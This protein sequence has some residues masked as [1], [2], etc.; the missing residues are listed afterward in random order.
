MKRQGFTLIELLVVIAIIGILVSLLFPAFAAVRAAARSTQ[1]Q[2][3][4][5]QFG[6][7]MAATAQASPTGQLL[8]GAFDHT[9]DGSVENF[10]WVGDAVKQGIL[11]GNLLCPSSEVWG[12]EKLNDL[13]GAGTA[14]NSPRTPEDQKAGSWTTL[15]G[16]DD[17]G[18]ANQLRANWVTTNLINKGYNTN[19]ATSWHAGRTAPLFTGFSTTSPNATII[20]DTKGALKNLQQ[21]VGGAADT[22]V[23]VG[24]I[25]V[26][27]L[28]SSAV[29]SQAIGMLGCAD[30]GDEKDSKLLLTLNPKLK[31]T[32]GAMLAE[33]QNDGPSFFNSAD[34]KVENIGATGTG[35][36][37]RTWNE[38]N[39]LGA[40]LPTAGQLVSTQFFL[41]DTRDWRAYHSGSVNVCF[42]DG[43]V[44]KLYDTNGDGYINP[45]F[46]IGGTLTNASIAGYTSNQCE[47]NPWELYPGTHL[48]KMNQTKNLE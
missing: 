11:P 43:S 9:R 37:G 28:D 48:S 26:G 3:N 24:P 23:T 33:T 14:G 47:A 5:R 31:L 39:N 12:S 27:V 29:P 4:L 30:K 16:I 18:T 40:V 6:L 13:I 7:S 34:G 41:Q 2:N 1:C 8:T 36:V 17:S 32:A 20:G 25:T 35:A 21:T 45:G 19:Y 22:R 15:V 42:A 44:R 10:S 46:N 38:L